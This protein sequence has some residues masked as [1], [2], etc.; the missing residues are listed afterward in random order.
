MKPG[1]DSVNPRRIAVGAGVRYA[2][3]EREE[4]DAVSGI[5]VNN[6]KFCIQFTKLNFLLSLGLKRKTDE[7]HFCLVFRDLQLSIQA[8][9][10]LSNGL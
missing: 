7:Y 9:F 6:S 3:R 5:L 1:A 10:H 2:V 8:R 4:R